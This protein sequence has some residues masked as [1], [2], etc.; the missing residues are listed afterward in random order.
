MPTRPSFLLLQ[1]RNAT[2]P[3]RAAEVR[4]FAREL[5]CGIERIKVHDLLQG[6]PRPA[7]IAAVDIV[8]LGGSGHYSVTGEET[9][10]HEAF[11][12]MRNLHRDSKPTFASCWGFQAMARALG[13]TVVRDPLRAEM[14]TRRAHLTPAGQQDPVF[15]PLG[16]EF[17]AQMGHED[18]VDVLPPGAVLLAS[19]DRVPHQAYT[20]AHRPLYCTQ[21]HPELNRDD[22][23]D[24]VREY[25]LYLQRIAGLPLDRFD[26]ICHDT[27]E[28]SA[29]LP[30]FVRHVLA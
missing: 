1:V 15:S 23:Y 10:L 29:L 28:T 24:R 11:E 20:F 9:W 26:E 22:M 3:M 12:T 27:P 13:G 30:R 18:C 2:D 19:T 16:A 8:L 25:P 4:S 21:F 7:A 6:A 17:G 14:G 5:G